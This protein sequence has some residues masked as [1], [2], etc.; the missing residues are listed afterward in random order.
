MPITDAQRIARQNNAKKAGQIKL[1][2]SKQKK[3]L[4]KYII[5]DSDDD[6]SYEEYDEYQDENDQEFGL[7]PSGV[8]QPRKSARKAPPKVNRT[9]IYRE[10]RKMNEREKKALA[11]MREI[12]EL[13]TEFKKFKSQSEEKPVVEAPKP[14]PN[15][16]SDIPKPAVTQAE[17]IKRNLI[18][19]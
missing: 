12:E 3:E 9:A 4:D 5:Y 1:E 16:L 19:F 11:L 15:K 14:E 6:E 17:I 18:N 8:K 2:K 10:A 13:K 7:A